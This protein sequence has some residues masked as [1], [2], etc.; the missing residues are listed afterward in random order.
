MN[1]LAAANDSLTQAFEPSALFPAAP[2]ESYTAGYSSKRKHH[3]GY[4][5]GK[6]INGI[7]TYYAEVGAKGKVTF[8]ANRQSESA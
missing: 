7:P 8:I 2:A 4:A 3:P 1:A 6:S 5:S